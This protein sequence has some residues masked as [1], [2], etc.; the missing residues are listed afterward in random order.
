MGAGVDVSKPRPRVAR[1]GGRV[2]ASTLGFLP[3]TRSSQGLR[4]TF[5]G[6]AEV[7][8]VELLVS[9][10]VSADGRAEASALVLSTTIGSRV[11][12]AAGAISAGS[13]HAPMTNDTSATTNIGRRIFGRAFTGGPR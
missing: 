9:A 8:A 2:G 10:G 11:V 13:E 5:G 12:D 3:G 1:C 4:S 6:V 7:V